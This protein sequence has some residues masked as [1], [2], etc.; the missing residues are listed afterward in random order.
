MPAIIR[1]RFGHMI[2]A[3]YRLRSHSHSWLGEPVLVLRLVAVCMCLGHN[4]DSETGR[5]NH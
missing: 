1:S 4:S 3:H 2:L 5:R